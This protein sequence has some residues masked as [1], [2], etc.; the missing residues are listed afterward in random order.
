MRGLWAFISPE[1]S[2]RDVAVRCL[3]DSF[4]RDAAGR[5][6]RLD[7]YL[8]ELD[9]RSMSDDMLETVLR[10]FVFRETDAGVHR[11]HLGQDPQLVG[12]IAKVKDA[13]SVHDQLVLSRRAD[14]FW[15]EDREVSRA[16]L[17]PVPL[18]FLEG[19]L[20][21]SSAH[22]LASLIQEV[23]LVLRNQ[24]LFR[25]E[26]PLWALTLVLR[27]ALRQADPPRWELEPDVSN[28]PGPGS[29]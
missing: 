9:W 26:I 3:A 28:N 4:V 22:S 1:L 2:D 21:E 12:T 15:V 10:R 6:I 7:A 25:R 8:G 27:V 14:G 19:R 16:G 18:E 17:E 29:L 23:A 5:L 24:S 13:V 20:R 11:L